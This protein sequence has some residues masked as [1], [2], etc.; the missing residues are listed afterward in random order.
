MGGTG[1]WKCLG[2]TATMATAVAMMTAE[3]CADELTSCMAR[4]CQ[5]R[6][7]FPWWWQ[8]RQSI[9]NT[10]K[11][12]GWDPRP[13]CD[14]VKENQWR[15]AA[16]WYQKWW[17]GSIGR[18]QHWRQRQ[19][20]GRLRVALDW[21]QGRLSKWA[22]RGGN[23]GMGPAT[24]MTMSWHMHINFVLHSNCFIHVK[25]HSYYLPMHFWPSNFYVL[26]PP[27]LCSISCQFSFSSFSFSVRNFLRNFPPF[28]LNLKMLSFNS[29]FP[30][31]QI[32]IK[33]AAPLLF[34]SPM[35]HYQF[36]SSLIT[37]LA[38][39]YVFKEMGLVLWCGWGWWWSG[40]RITLQ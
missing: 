6:Q 12:G 34:P 31:I 7:W 25:I 28:D 15:T 22:T 37:I 35:S 20:V 23:D 29:F 30:Y 17:R 13:L 21:Q 40:S 16:N 11:E 14:A 5:W 38:T 9:R 26:F 2:A 32:Q 36:T 8:R 4:T 10:T 18:W 19:R 27:C 1:L 39:C 3:Q 24:A 33:S